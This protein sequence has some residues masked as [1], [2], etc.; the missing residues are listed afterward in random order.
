MPGNMW[1]DGARDGQGVAVA[2]RHFVEADLKAGRLVELFS[3][4]DWGGYHIVTRTGVM[5]PAVKAFVE[6]LR[7]QKS[8]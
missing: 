6:W 1:L 8:L 4:N 7:R 5:R 3:E 2:V